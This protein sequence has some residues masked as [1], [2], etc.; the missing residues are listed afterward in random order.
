M[1]S[2]RSFT[3]LPAL[4]ESLKDLEVIAGNMFWSWN[5]EFVELFKRVDSNLWL[6]CGHNPVKM[7]GN[8][9]QAK[10]NELAENK[11]F[12]AQL[13]NTV[14]K[15]KSYLDRPTWYEKVCSKSTKPIIAYF[16]AEF[17]IHECL[18]IYAGGLGILAGDHLKSASDLGVPLVGVGLLYQMGYF[19]Q[20]LSIDGEQREEYVENDF[21]SMPIE[22]VRKESGRPLT[23]SVE[24]PGRCVVADV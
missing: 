12:L 22:L 17:G 18:P 1:P 3:V 11:G 7:L 21:H 2:V 5:P 8:I 4:P 6:A 13:Q 14:E 19:R 24:Y 20:D 16:S 23:I 15:L 9:S 10:L